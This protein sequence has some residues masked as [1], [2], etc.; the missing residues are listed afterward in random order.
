MRYPEIDY[1][2]HPAYAPFRRDL[3]Y[4]E[5]LI[6]QQIRAVDTSHAE[7]CAITAPSTEDIADVRTQIRQPLGRVLQ[8]VK[9]QN[10][11]ILAEEWLHA[12]IDW[13]LADLSSEHVR[14][15]FS[16]QEYK[17]QSLSLNQS[18]QLQTMQNPQASATTP[19]R[20]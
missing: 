8:H 4:D 2:D 12:C 16:S 15:F 9:E 18:G 19:S 10:I 6:G 17:N 13:T 14:R 1:G 3:V 11:S 20:T 7:F 5:E